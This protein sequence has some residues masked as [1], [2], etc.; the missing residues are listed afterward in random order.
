MGPVIAAERAI[1][2]LDTT[3]S[4]LKNH[5]PYLTLSRLHEAV[6][7][8]QLDG[9]ADVD[10]EKLLL[11]LHDPMES[12]QPAAVRAALAIHRT[13]G[14][15]HRLNTDGLAFDAS[16]L[17]ALASRANDDGMAFDPPALDKESLDIAA[18]EHWVQACQDLTPLPPMIAAALAFARLH[19]QRPCGELSPRVARVFVPMLF[20][21][22][23][24]TETPCLFLSQGLRQKDV[25]GPHTLLRSDND[26][27]EAFCTATAA[28]ADL[29]RRRAEHLHRLHTRYH[30]A[31]AD[32]RSTNAARKAVDV[33]FERPLLDLTTLQSLPGLGRSASGRLSKRGSLLVMERLLQAGMV[34]EISDRERFRLYLAWDII[35]L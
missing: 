11:V 18:F 16:D 6:R 35:R 23:Q 13:L 3:L 27:V 20:Q 5:G 30:A 17:A 4:L 29:C 32:S 28:A 14:K 8:A 2:R 7:S 25:V 33:L 10:V 26:W 12:Y 15:A 19:Q 22:L 31:F 21:A 9:T 34:E 24:L 1:A